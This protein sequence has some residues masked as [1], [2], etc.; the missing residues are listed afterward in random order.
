MRSATASNRRASL[1]FVVLHRAPATGCHIHV[2]AD[3]TWTQTAPLDRV[4]HHA[5]RGSVFGVD[6][7]DERSV[8]VAIAPDLTAAGRERFAREL[9]L[10]LRTQPSVHHVLLHEDLVA[11]SVGSAIGELIPSAS[12]DAVLE[13]AAAQGRPWPLQVCGPLLQLRDAPDE[14]AAPIGEPLLRGELVRGV[15]RVGR[16]MRVRTRAGR[17]GWTPA[18]FVRGSKLVV[19]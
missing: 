5:G 17:V 8:G 15:R 4:G 6:R 11:P 14:D 9:G 7:L 12:I 19:S 10:F 2:A 3:G 13:N 18:L 16:W 1:R